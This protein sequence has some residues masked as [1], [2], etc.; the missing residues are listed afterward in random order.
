[1]CVLLSDLQKEA[2]SKYG[3][4]TQYRLEISLDPSYF[5]N[6]VPAPLRGTQIRFVP[7]LFQMGVD[8]RQW[9]ANAGR[10]VTTQ[11]KDR[12]K[13]APGV[14]DCCADVEVNNEPVCGLIDDGDDDDEGGVADTEILVI[15]NLE[16]FRKL[17]V[18]AHTINPTPFTP[19]SMSTLSLEQMQAL[20]AHS[21]LSILSDTI[22]ASAGKMEHG[23]LDHAATACQRSVFVV[24]AVF[25]LK[26]ALTSFFAIEIEDSEVA[27][28][29]FARVE[30]IEQQ[31][32]SPSSRHSFCRDSWIKKMHLLL[33]MPSFH[34][35]RYLPIQ[36]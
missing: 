25:D 23:V 15:L 11:I 28:Q 12:T 8:I 22:R 7:V 20:P 29:C 1:M 2:T 3:T 9:G 18:Y 4:E 32:K 31:C 17:N 33:K 21:L 19:S 34:L 35:M 10:S 30:R 5:Q 36:R 13:A 14:D 26:Y 16:G 27:A 24:K 6:R